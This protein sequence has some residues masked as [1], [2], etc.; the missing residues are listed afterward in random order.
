MPVEF[1]DKRRVEKR[2]TVAEEKPTIPASNDHTDGSWI[3][4]DIYEGELFINLAD[5]IV[6]TRG[7]DD[8]IIIINVEGQPLPDTDG[9]SAIADG[10]AYTAGETIFNTTNN[11][12]TF[13]FVTNNFTTDT[14][15]DIADE[16]LSGNLVESNTS[17]V[18]IT[19]K[20]YLEKGVDTSDFIIYPKDTVVV[21]SSTGD[22]YR[23]KI[24]TDNSVLLNNGTFWEII[25]NQSV[26]LSHNK[27]LYVSKTGNDSNS[28]LN[29]NNPKLSIEAAEAAAFALTP[30]ITNQIVIKGIGAGDY[31]EDVSIREWIHVDCRDFSLDGSL[32]IADNTTVRFRKLQRTTTGGSVIEKAAGAGFAK[33]TVD[34]L[35]ISDATQNGFLLN[36]GV[37][38][39]DAGVLSVD[40]GI[41]IKAKNGSRVSFIISEVQLLNG[42]VGIGTQVAGGSPNFFS[43]NI[44]YASDDSSGVLFKSKVV[45][46]ILNIQ[47]GSLK[48]DTL[49]DLTE[50]VVL[51]IFANEATG[52][53]T[54]DSLAKVNVVNLDGDSNLAGAL[55]LG[56]TLK[57]G[58]SVVVDGILDEDDLVSDSDVK[59]ATQQSIKAYADS[60]LVKALTEDYIVQ[61]DENNEGAPVATNEFYPESH[62]GTTLFNQAYLIANWSLTFELGQKIENNWQVAEKI[63]NDW[64][65]ERK[66]QNELIPITLSLVDI[67]SGNETRILDVGSAL[68]ADLLIL[69]T[70]VPA[71]TTVAS[72]EADPAVLELIA[73]RIQYLKN[74][75][76]IS[77]VSVLLPAYDGDY[78]IKNINYSNGTFQLY[79]TDG[80]TTFDSTALGSLAD[81][82]IT[83]TS[84]VFN[85]QIETVINLPS[86]TK[87]TIESKNGET[88]LFLRNL[89]AS[90]TAN[91]IITQT[92]L[93]T[94]LVGADEGSDMLTFLKKGS[95][96]YIIDS[97][98]FTK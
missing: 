73:D 12:T 44:L 84:G 83:F 41:G 68:G 40:G 29:V 10:T 38:H 21:E 82:V 96:V 81:G 72:T 28:G 97:A 80:I 74:D 64:K 17:E 43:G 48:T 23:A 57:V 78:M 88:P 7:T 89:L 91:Q 75:D 39:I 22:L 67:W 25:S 45:G 85:P 98:T 55:S 49:Y 8:K 16:I 47:G 24:Q 9:L 56:T 95:F 58:E 5:G 53:E 52:T 76:L 59:L 1:D 33:V 35:V 32:T 30:S 6:Y 50:D 13:Y 20:D 42:G 26:T 87:I 70:T 65:L 15:F 4:T 2:S 19:I 77:L 54:A 69:D 90:A 66:D 37:A 31:V 93:D 63:L 34:L 11:I 86:Y 62:Q 51:N 94:Q 14:P 61:G 92:D 18:F 36:S 3:A 27:I 71:I 60:K 79:E 46:D